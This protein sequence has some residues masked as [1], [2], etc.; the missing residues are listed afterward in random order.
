MLKL[1]SSDDDGE[2][3]PQGLAL[4]RAS[5]EDSDRTRLLKEVLKDSVEMHHKATQDVPKA[6]PA[7]SSSSQAATGRML[8]PKP[9]RSTGLSELQDIISG[10]GDLRCSDRVDELMSELAGGREFSP[11]LRESGKRVNALCDALRSA[12]PDT[13]AAA[14]SLAALEHVPGDPG[15]PDAVSMVP[16]RI[17]RSVAKYITGTV[18]FK[19]LDDLQSNMRKGNDFKH[20]RKL[21]PRTV[22][23]HQN[24]VLLTDH[25]LKD[26]QEFRKS[27]WRKTPP[28][29]SDV[30]TPALL[31]AV[32]RRSASKGVSL[33]LGGKAR[34]SPT[35][36]LPRV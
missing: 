17:D 22:S 32:S 26:G 27:V 12:K 2:E 15:L 34:S 8:A 10:L 1:M 24:L 35:L 36:T 3:L 6:R 25:L 31:H 19:H 30:T 9:K 20:F 21:F 28:A 11:V 18:N 16:S 5:F 7:R 14:A 29:N 23:H 4:I 13:P 33:H